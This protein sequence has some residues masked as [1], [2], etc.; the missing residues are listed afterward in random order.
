MAEKEHPP[1]ETNDELSGSAL[2]ESD[3]QQAQRIMARTGCTLAEAVDS[4]VVFKKA[5][6]NS[7]PADPNEPIRAISGIQ[8]PPKL[9]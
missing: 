7:K 2:N 5:L 3:I 8:R 6:A 1:S 9:S 4:V